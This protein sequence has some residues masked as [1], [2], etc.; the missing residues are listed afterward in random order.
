MKASHSDKKQKPTEHNH[1]TRHAEKAVAD[2][3]NCEEDEKR[4][5]EINKEEMTG[6]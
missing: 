5:V 3:K 6:D 1:R 4:D 2:A